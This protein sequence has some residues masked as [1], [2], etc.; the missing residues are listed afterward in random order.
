MTITLITIIIFF[1][2]VEVGTSSFIL[3]SA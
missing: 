3:F 1:S 2:I